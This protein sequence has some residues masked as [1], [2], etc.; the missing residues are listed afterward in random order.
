MSLVAC[1]L[2]V[3]DSDGSGNLDV[4]EMQQIVK[5]VYGDSFRTS[6]YVNP[7]LRWVVGWLDSSCVSMC[8]PASVTQVES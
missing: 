2:V 8:V 6:V 3:L 1:L 4:G 7:P 5:E